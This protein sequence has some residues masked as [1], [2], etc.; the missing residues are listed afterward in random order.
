M[1]VTSRKVCSEINQI[2]LSEGTLRVGRFALEVSLRIF[3]FAQRRMQ[4][5][6]YI[7]RGN[8]NESKKVVD[9]FSNYHRH[10]CFLFLPNNIT[11]DKYAAN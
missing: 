5:V 7:S 3:I 6:L 9:Y 10:S 11:R 8:F 1:L 2:N 4:I